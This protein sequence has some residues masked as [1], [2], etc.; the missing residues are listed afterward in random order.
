MM[1]ASEFFP[2]AAG[3]FDSAALNLLGYSLAG[4]YA[5]GALKEGYVWNFSDGDIL[6]TKTGASYSA[7]DDRYVSGVSY[8][9]DL[10]SGG[11]ATASSQYSGFEASRAFD[12]N[13]ATLWETNNAT[14]GWLRYAFGVAKIVNR[15][16]IQC[17]DF[18][19]RA[20][21]DFT[22]EGWNGSGWVVLKT[23]TG[24]TGWGVREARV[25]DFE[26]TTG[27]TDYRINVTANNGGS[28][29]DIA[30]CSMFTKTLTNATLIPSALSSS[31]AQSRM[32][33]YFLVDPVGA[34]TLG[35]D[36]KI[37]VSRDGGVNWSGYGNVAEVAAY[38]A[39]YNLIKADFPASSLPAAGT[40][41][42]WE[43]TTYNEKE[44]RVRAAALF[45]E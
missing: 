23:V 35:T 11:A 3:G 21:K 27:Y 44:L 13:A 5:S 19:N 41:L 31:A 40:S 16:T 28:N 26:N 8:G 30:E 6:A 38:D 32:T 24:S 25:F 43:L 4:G 20:P 29:L 7:D 9:S 39:S 15:A 1:R 33:V 36:L 34:F 14:T 42:K 37:R 17:W 22:I 2:T 10:C 12:D 18:A 45:A